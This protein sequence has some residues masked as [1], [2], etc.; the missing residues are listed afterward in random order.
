[1]LVTYK[2]RGCKYNWNVAGNWNN[3]L[4][5]IQR[6]RMFIMG[7]LHVRD[8]PLFAYKEASW[9]KS[10]V[11]HLFNQ[12][13]K[14]FFF[15]GIQT[16]KTNYSIPPNWPTKTNLALH[17]FYCPAKQHCHIGWEWIQSIYNHDC[18]IWGPIHLLTRP[19]ACADSDWSPPFL[20]VRNRGSQIP[21]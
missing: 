11:L 12:T 1:M 20:P 21:P 18:L 3:F 6:V 10:S 4:L 19:G 17:F 13:W 7:N 5:K 2:P 16:W 8:N 14:P 9:T 15:E